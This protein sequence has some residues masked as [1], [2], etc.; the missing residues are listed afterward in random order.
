[1]SAASSQAAQLAR[2][3][4]GAQSGRPGQTAALPILE[5][6]HGSAME[7]AQLR[8]RDREGRP[9]CMLEV[10]WIYP[11]QQGGCLLA[12]KS[13]GNSFLALA[14][15]VEDFTTSLIFQGLRVPSFQISFSFFTNT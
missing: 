9:C 8:R 12:V 5:S 11:H 1:M 7:W 4:E 14:L 13:P 3:P 2:F 6:E 10:T 15:L